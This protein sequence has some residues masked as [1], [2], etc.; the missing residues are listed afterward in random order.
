MQI[1]NCKLQI[2]GLARS[3]SEWAW[4]SIRNLLRRGGCNLQC[5][6]IISVLAAPIGAQEAPATPAATTPATAEAKP[7]KPPELPPPIP[8]E[9]QPYRVRVSVAFDEH[10]SLTTRVRQAI[11]KRKRRELDEA[12]ASSFGP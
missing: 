2:V 8:M 12:F 10:P 11:Q 9:L 6:F 7:A 5:L 3:A 1:A 4:P